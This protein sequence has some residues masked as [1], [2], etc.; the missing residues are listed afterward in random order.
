MPSGPGYSAELKSDSVTRF[1]FP[2]GSYW[3]GQE[4]E[5]ASSSR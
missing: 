4:S 3:Q 2:T 5:I 1:V